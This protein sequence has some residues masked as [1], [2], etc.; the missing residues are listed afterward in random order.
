M[1]AGG[2]TPPVG[3]ESTRISDYAPGPAGAPE[4]ERT[5]ERRSMDTVRED[6]EEEEEPLAARYVSSGAAQQAE[7]VLAQFVKMKRSAAKRSSSSSSI[8]SVASASSSRAQVSDAR[9]VV[10]TDD[11]MRRPTSPVMSDT[12][13]YSGLSDAIVDN[14]PDWR[15]RVQALGEGSVEPIK[16]SERG[17]RSGQPAA[18]QRTVQ[19][20]RSQEG[21]SS[22]PRPNNIGRPRSTRSLRQRGSRLEVMPEDIEAEAEAMSSGGEMQGRDSLSKLRTD[23]PISSSSSLRSSSPSPR[24]TSPRWAPSRSSSSATSMSSQQEFDRRARSLDIERDHLKP[25]PL[26]RAISSASTRPGSV[27][28]LG[29]TKSNKSWD[30][31]AIAASASSPRGLGKFFQP[32]LAS[33]KASKPEPVVAV[34]NSPNRTAGRATSLR[35]VSLSSRRFYDEDDHDDAQSLSGISI[36]SAPQLSPMRPPRNPAR[37]G[38]AT[39][40]KPIPAA[41]LEPDLPSR[42]RY[43][44][45]SNS[46]PQ[47]ESPISP[48]AERRGLSSP[49]SPAEQ[50]AARERSAA[51][52][53]PAPAPIFGVNAPPSAEPASESPALSRA[54]SIAPPRPLSSHLAPSSVD[55]GLMSLALS[56][57]TNVSKQKTS[58]RFGFFRRSSGQDS[59]A[60]RRGFEPSLD[61]V[62][63][64]LDATV[65]RKKL[66]SDEVLIETVAVGLDRFDRE[67]TWQLA[68]VAGGTGW[69]AGRSVV[70]NVLAVGTSVHRIKKGD[71][72]WGLS[73][74]KKVSSASEAGHR[75]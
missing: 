38:D 64:T 19:Q 53:P 29:S 37:L 65:F 59:S 47:A 32:P 67:R 33:S 12:S 40:V 63:D 49:F 13:A 11:R 42:D 5:S 15:D 56:P 3:M 75:R 16:R 36:A 24:L 23:L 51:P 50:P 31:E 74:L 41:L 69:V 57:R 72:V 26:A 60:S 17:S 14:S 25:S 44:V 2:Y 61:L 46:S 22:G 54:N 39:I 9:P 21:S 66:S 28:S 71:L 30:Y 10:G 20:L 34:I 52:P 70:G 27:R 35:N 48:A 73:P 58:R 1:L 68:K 43:S 55:F 8:D 7:P 4:P 62:Y 18:P 6:P 45:S